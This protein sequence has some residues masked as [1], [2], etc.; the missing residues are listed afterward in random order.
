MLVTQLMVVLDASIVTVALPDMARS[1]DLSQTGLSWVMNAYT[2]AF[3]GLLLLGARAGDLLGRRR[4]FLGGMALFVLASLIGGL[5]P[6]GAWL[7]ASRAVQGVGA[8]FAAPTVLAMITISV[9]EGRA[10]TRAMGLFTAVSIGGV[11]LGLLAGGMLTDWVSWRWVMFVNVPIGI[12]VL[13]AAWL[14][15]PETQRHT[16]RVDVAGAITST[17]GMTALVYGFVR[18]ADAGWSDV[19]SV[20]SFV[21]AAV[22]LVGFVFI[23]RRAEAPVVPLALFRDRMRVGSYLG[24]MLLVAGMMGMFFFMTQLLQT[25]VGYSPL[26]AGLAFLP[27]TVG[28]LLASQL[29]ARRLVEAIGPR[30]TMVLGSLVS[31]SAVFWLSHTSSDPAYWTI[32]VP[33]FLMGLGNGTVFVPITVAALRGVEPRHAGAA[34][35]L[36]NVSQQ[37]GATL[38]LAVLVTV[39]SA[40]SRHAVAAGPAGRDAVEQA[41]HVFVTGADS[42]L[43]AASVLIVLVAVVVAVTNRAPRSPA[44]VAVPV[45]AD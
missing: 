8:A 26:Q 24:R 9:P 17:L 19:V 40:A 12:G 23:E 36:V 41:R 34:A 6:S 5:A 20:A 15:L 21:A 22:L 7:I 35:G 37:I 18:A 10:R 16:G 43:L 42:A 1:L 11:A 25:E 2:L 30:S 14:V 44:A 4:V 29:S 3:G 28:V 13:V 39:F 33:L 31:A 38:G 45:L 32:G 27:T